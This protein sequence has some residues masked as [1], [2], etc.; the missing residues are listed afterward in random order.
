MKTAKESVS[1]NVWPNKSL[2]DKVVKVW[3]YHLAR[4]AGCGMFSSVYAKHG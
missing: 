3:D 1:P 4:H 2:R